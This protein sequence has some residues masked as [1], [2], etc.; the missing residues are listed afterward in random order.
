MVPGVFN[1]NPAQAVASFHRQAELDTEIACFG[2]GQPLTNNATAALRTATQQ[3]P[4][5]KP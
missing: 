3:L 5:P 4:R 1:T 2:H